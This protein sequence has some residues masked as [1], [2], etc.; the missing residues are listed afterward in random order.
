MFNRMAKDAPIRGSLEILQTLVQRSA[1]D[2]I[3]ALMRQIS[4]WCSGFF[5]RQCM[6]IVVITQQKRQ[7]QS[8]LKSLLDLL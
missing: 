7:I 8:I 1:I 5:L 4:K 2:V 6:V 3:L